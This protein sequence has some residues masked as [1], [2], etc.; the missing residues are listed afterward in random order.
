MQHTGRNSLSSSSSQF[1]VDASSVSSSPSNNNTTTG[2][3][4][5]NHS[6]TIPSSFHSSLTEGSSAIPYS[7]STHLPGINSHSC[8]HHPLNSSSM[9]PTA[10]TLISSSPSSSA[11]GKEMNTSSTTTNTTNTSNPSS[12]QH[13]HSP[14]TSSAPLLNHHHH[15]H[16][17]NSSNN[18]TTTTTHHPQEQVTTTTTTSLTTTK[19]QAL[20]SSLL[21]TT[22]TAVVL[23][24]TNSAA[25]NT[26]LTTSVSASS[27]STVIPSSTLKASQHSPRPRTISN[28]H[29]Y[30]Y[31]NTHYGNPYSPSNSFISWFSSFSGSSG[32]NS[33]HNN[34]NSPI[35]GTSKKEFKQSMPSLWTCFMKARNYSIVILLILCVVAS[36]LFVL[37]LRSNVFSKIHNTIRTGADDALET[38]EEAN[39]IYDASYDRYRI[40]SSKDQV[41]RP[42]WENIQKNDPRRPRIAGRK[43]ASDSKRRK[44]QETTSSSS[45]T[46]QQ[47]QIEK[48]A[49]TRI[50]APQQP[51][52]EQPKLEQENN[53]ATKT[54]T[55]Q[56]EMGPKVIQNMDDSSNKHPIPV[57]PEPITYVKPLR[58]DGN[59]VRTTV[60]PKPAVENEENPDFKID[61]IYVINLKIREDRKLKSIRRLNTLGGI[62]SNYSFFEP[63]YGEA[64]S[65]KDIFNHVSITTYKAI[66]EGRS[67]DYQLAT[68]GAVGC[69]LTHTNIWKDMIEKGYEK[70]LIFEDDFEITSPYDEI[71]TYFA[72]L[73]KEFDVAFM[74]FSL[75]P[76]SGE[77]ERYNDY[78]MTTSAT[79]VYG[80][81][82]YIITRKAALKL[83]EKAFPI[84]LQLDAFINHYVTFTGG[85]RL[86]S[87]KLLFG[88]EIIELFN[89]NVQDYCWKCFANILMDNFLSFDLVINVF[90]VVAVVVVILIL[91]AKYFSRILANRKKGKPERLAEWAHN[92]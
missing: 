19:Q 22:T 4:T 24:N 16:N 74:Y 48:P 9:T 72:H 11:Q 38:L 91:Y 52:A 68:K 67:L 92:E 43:Q 79:R 7:T 8:R 26:S 75:F 30:S 33:Y 25:I 58:P 66:S 54:T 18:T 36:L 37:N 63:V 53:K 31:R 70:I 41:E 77:F 65:D 61:H 88:H 69:Y 84:D 81:A 40:P 50:D 56:P 59:D 87:N 12:F 3:S 23:N 28:P 73:P 5:N 83:L 86:Y 2:G 10:A 34:F 13:Q 51:L 60:V 80:A 21:M 64:L 32:H 1:S 46:K 6:S 71:M 39:T 47:P 17:N 78:W 76:G 15:H 29:A 55:V 57:K 35:M 49:P 45:T 90:I 42:D 89:T 44:K 85:L 27:S 82:S 20:K 62:F 14:A